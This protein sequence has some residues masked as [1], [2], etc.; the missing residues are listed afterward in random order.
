MKVSCKQLSKRSA[1]S[2]PIKPSHWSTSLNY[3]GQIRRTVVRPIFAS[4]KALKFHMHMLYNDKDH[5]PDSPNPV[6]HY[7]SKAHYGSISN[8]D[9]LF[10][11]RM[12]GVS[13]V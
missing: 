8:C 1:Q 10:T 7:R 4:G 6:V 2:L 13:Y 3:D 5:F 12:T 11:E 9:R